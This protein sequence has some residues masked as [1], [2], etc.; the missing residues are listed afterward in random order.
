M[1]LRWKLTGVSEPDT[2]VSVV[3]FTASQDWVVPAGVTSISVVCIGGGGGGAGCDGVSNNSSGGGGGGALRYV[4]NI[5]VTPGETLTVVV[6]LGGTPGT[7][8]PTD[9]GN[10]GESSVSRGAAVLCSAAGGSGGFAESSTTP[11]GGNTG[12]GTGGDG[13]DG[14]TGGTNSAGG[15]GGGAAGYTGNGGNG[16]WANNAVGGTQ[17]SGGG[18]GGGGTTVSGSAGGGGTGA[19]GEGPSGVTAGNTLTGGTGGSSGT[20]GESAAGGA[21][22]LY[23]GGGGTVED[24]T[25]GPGGAGGPGAVTIIYPGD[26][27]NFPDGVVGLPSGP[28]SST[29]LGGVT[30]L[31]GINVSGTV[32]A[33][34]LTSNDLLVIAYEGENAGPGDTPN[35]TVDGVAPTTAV[36]TAPASGDALAG[37]YYMVPTSGMVGNSALLVAQTVG[38]GRRGSINAFRLVNGATGTLFT[39]DISQVVST[40]PITNTLSGVQTDDVIYSSGHYSSGPGNTFS[41]NSGNGTQ[42]LGAQGSGSTGGGDTYVVTG[43][44]GT[45]TITYTASNT[46]NTEG[47]A[48][49]SAVFRNI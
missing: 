45:V 23:G 49:V 4:N 27:F 21:G 16:T 48:V 6:G 12:V 20:G 25:A 5:T 37:I 15:A 10:G 35:V 42:F 33:S 14:G 34:S 11:T 9:G 26:S 31:S 8:A 32:D 19:L 43:A 44:N 41:T 2:G 47:D 39:T 1:T 29:F 3:P 18:A 28:L 36:A 38:G 13:G 17:P 7:A 24:D 22:G 40:S 46:L 30:N